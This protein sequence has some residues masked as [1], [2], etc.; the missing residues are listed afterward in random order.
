MS[1]ALTALSDEIATTIMQGRDR[2]KSDRWAAE[3]S[4]RALS[5]DGGGAPARR[6]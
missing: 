4:S 2:R 1:E 5:G 6:R 3:R